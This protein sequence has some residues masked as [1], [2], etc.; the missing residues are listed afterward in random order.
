MFL[1]DDFGSFLQV[2]GAR[3]VAKPGPVMQ[4]GVE[5]RAR[6]GLDIGKAF[7]E[8]FVVGNDRTHLGLLEHD[9]RHPDA[10]RIA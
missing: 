1:H 5:A 4:Y 10:I 9:L 2:A 7:Q 6:Q 3:V 8:A